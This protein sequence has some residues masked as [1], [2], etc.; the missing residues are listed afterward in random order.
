MRQLP[1]SERHMVRRY[2][3]KSRLAVY[4]SRW[5]DSHQQHTVDHLRGKSRLDI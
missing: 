5:V 1:V 2:A 3:D 4:Q